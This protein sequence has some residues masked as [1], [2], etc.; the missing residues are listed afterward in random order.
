MRQLDIYIDGS[1]LLEKRRTEYFEY[2][3]STSIG[4]FDDGGAG[5]FGFLHHA[6]QLGHFQEILGLDVVSAFFGEQWY[7]KKTIENFD[8]EQYLARWF[9]LSHALD[10]LRV[11]D[12][13]PATEKIVGELQKLQTRVDPILLSYRRVEA[14]SQSPAEK[15]I[16]NDKSDQLSFEWDEFRNFGI[17]ALELSYLG[18]PYSV[19]VGSWSKW[20]LQL[21]EAD[22]RPLDEFWNPTEAPK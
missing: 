10:S 5:R 12:P 17:V 22:L 11:G 20:V 4:L 6:Q 15:T 8:P 16:N 19:C 18:E 9:A 21:D 13:L 2:T 14:A 1:D 3:D 7:S